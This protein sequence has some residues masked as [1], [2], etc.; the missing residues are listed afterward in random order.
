MRGPEP[1]G[2]KP[3][4]RV[5]ESRRMRLVLAS[6]SPR[7]AQ[8]LRDA[9][10]AFEALAPDV[11]ESYRSGESAVARVTRLAEEKARAAAKQLSGAAIVAGF[12]TEV[13]LGNRVFGKPASPDDAR[14]MLRTL[15]GQTH[16]V[17][18]GVC[19]LRSENARVEHEITRVSFAPLSDA[20]IAAYV[21]TGEPL[22]KAGAYAVQGRGGRFVTLIDGCYFNVVG[23]PLARV[24]RL[25]RE[26]GW[27]E[28]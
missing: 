3:P 17:I 7:R 19:L 4:L 20:E 2:I 28:W 1:G 26:I 21:A 16:E 6:T 18:T 22:D 5:L 12:D 14:D 24:C 10:I 25:L 27:Q 13:V 8:V 9:G 23:L 15:S 11:D